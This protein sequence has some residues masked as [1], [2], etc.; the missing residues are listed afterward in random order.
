MNAQAFEVPSLVLAQSLGIGVDLGLL[1]FRQVGAGSSL[2]IIRA[3]TDQPEYP[4][5]AAAVRKWFKLASRARTARNDVI[6]TP[7][8]SSTE[9]G[10]VNAKFSTRPPRWE[11]ADPAQIDE[12]VTLLREAIDAGHALLADDA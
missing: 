6:H 8:G 5:D 3:L 9:G 12:R 4:L 2:A 11:P 1:V 7:W 10:F